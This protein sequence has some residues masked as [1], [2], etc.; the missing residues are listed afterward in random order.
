VFVAVQ[1]PG[2]GGTFADPISF[3]PDYVLNPSKAKRGEVYGPRPSVVQVFTS[4]K[5]HGPKK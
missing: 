4:A 3:F 5:G 2:E 1:H